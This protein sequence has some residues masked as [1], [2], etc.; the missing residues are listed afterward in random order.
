MTQLSENER[1]KKQL[2]NHI[3]FS[4]NNAIWMDSS[5]VCNAAG[6][7]ELVT[8]LH[9]ESAK[10][11]GRKDN[12]TIRKRHIR[13]AVLNLLRAWQIEQVKY[14]AHHRRPS[15]YSKIPKRFNPQSIRSTFLHV[16]QDLADLGYLSI[17]PGYPAHWHKVSEGKNFKRQSQASKMIAREKLLLLFEKHGLLDAFIDR[18]PETECI[19][20]RPEK[21]KGQSKESLDYTDTPE[22]M[23]MRRILQAYNSLLRR[24]FIDIPNFPTMGVSNKEGNKTINVD[25]LNKFV[26][27]VF[28]DMRW[29]HG[30]RFYGGWW[31]GLSKAWRQRILIDDQPVV[32]KDYSGCQVVILYAMQG[33]DYWRTVGKDPYRLTGF[34]QTERMRDLLKFVFTVAVNSKSRA[35][36]LGTVRK[37]TQP[38]GDHGWAHDER[39][40]FSDIIDRLVAQ[41]GPIRH[42][43]FGANSAMLQRIDSDIAEHV[44]QHM[45]EKGIPV[46]AIHDSFVVQKE[47]GAEL[48]RLMEDSFTRVMNSQTE[49]KLSFSPR[50]TT[51]EEAVPPKSLEP[52]GIDFTEVMFGPGPYRLHWGEPGGPLGFMTAKKFEFK[53]ETY[54][55]RLEAHR[56]RVWEPN[57]FGQAS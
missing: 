39:F 22:T 38:D 28:N 3:A 25:H 6:I 19:V 53:R 40:D 47:H 52:P 50:I 48:E 5:L 34:E 26:R 12:P 8:Q 20:L 14:V 36:V 17:E 57:F 2:N 23:R 16:T 13:L 9:A 49:F 33:I 1:R 29:D 32:E 35:S 41:H 30:G 44:I 55:G 37:K 54:Q 24:T 43:F 11:N 10:H 56:N 45:T 7:D 15:R 46:L 21:I 51:P 42:R 27:R 31:Q 4:L 18:H